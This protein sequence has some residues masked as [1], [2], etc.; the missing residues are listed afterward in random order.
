MYRE[1]LFVD[2]HQPDCLH[3]LGMIAFQNGDKQAAIDLIRRAI[4]IKGNAASY[5]SNLG[6][7]LQSQGE[8]AGAGACFQRALV[9]KPE[10]AEVWVNLG[11]IYKAQGDVQSSLACYRRALALRPDLA[12]AAA[13]ESMALLLNGDFETGWIH[14]DTALEDEGLQHADAELC[15]TGDGME[16]GWSL[17]GC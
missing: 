14:F 16:K 4:E 10:L 12:E 17:D 11:N 9:L 6:N 5:H 13:G 8:L 2:P 15:A 7:V 1:I 3:L